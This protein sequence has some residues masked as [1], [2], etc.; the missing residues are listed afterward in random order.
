MKA[1]SLLFTALYLMSDVAKVSKEKGP[2]RFNDFLD[3]SNNSVVEHCLHAVRM[4]RRLGWCS[5]NHYFCKY[6][7]ALVLLFNHTHFRSRL[8]P[9]SIL[10]IHDFIMTQYSSTCI[11]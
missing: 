3:A 7:A 4:A 9:E 1:Q 11:D 8:D 5:L 2:S 6:P 10:A